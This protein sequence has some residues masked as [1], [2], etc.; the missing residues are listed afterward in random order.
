MSDLLDIA[1]LACRTAV[2][3]GAEF[4]QAVARR[5]DGQSID[6][7]RGYVKSAERG[8]RVS[9]SVW[10]F[11]RGGMGFANATDLALK[12]V[13]RAAEEAA[14][15]AKVAEPDPDFVS[16][17]KP[18]EYPA[19]EGLYDERIRGVS[20]QD[21][22]AWLS[23]AAEEARA[24][25]ADAIINGGCWVGF[26]ESALA[27]SLGIRATS[28]GSSIGLTIGA[29]IRRGDDVGVFQ[30]WTGGRRLDDL[31][32]QGLGT[33]VAEQALKMLGARDM[34]TCELPVVFGPLASGSL[35]DGLLGPANAE[36]V[37]RGRSFLAGKKGKRVA[38]EVL[39]IVD[40]P[41]IPGG[42]SSGR[43]DGE[44]S[45]R[46]TQTLVENGIL[47]TYLHNSYTASKGK[48]PNTAHATAPVTGIAPT[49][50]NP[51]LG[52]QTAAEIISSVHKGLYLLAGGVEPNTTTGDFS[53]TVDFGFKIEHGELAYP[54]KNT[55]LGGS[56][57][58]LTHAIEAISSDYRAEPGRI[59]PTILVGKAR[60]AGR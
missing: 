7:E 53:D 35:I 17:P 14:A 32:P 54:V 41:L 4:V 45:P 37:Q 26:G 2:E 20:A 42:L 52:T 9:V 18:A 6:I 33:R 31:K 19:V 13:R 50:S 60:I 44:G 29:N 30:D 49:N 39:T 34:P 11:V 1:D 10:C 57:L 15:L 24:V 43:Y 55:M 21:L 27:N 58:E 51:T 23:Q 56:F 47:L 48:E 5:G 8:E 46:R 40:D 16:L 28:S 36:S 12:S 59:M 38:S 25:A 22:M 3:S